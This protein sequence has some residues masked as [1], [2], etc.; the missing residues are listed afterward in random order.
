MKVRDALNLSLREAVKEGKIDRKKHA[1]TI[2]AARKVAGVM[3]DEEWPIVRNKI[4]NVSP[5]VFLKYCEA[6]GL[7]IKEPKKA[8]K[9]EEP[10]PEP[11]KIISVLDRSRWKK[12]A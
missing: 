7:T 6:L 9:S 3:D 2:E 4:D 5:S 12:K 10:E 11:E 8:R 1:A